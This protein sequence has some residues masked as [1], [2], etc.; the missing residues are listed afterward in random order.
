MSKDNWLDSVN[1]DLEDGLGDGLDDFEFGND[2][3]FNDSF[4][5]T[6]TLLDELENIDHQEKNGSR[7]NSNGLAD[8]S[9]SVGNVESVDEEETEEDYIKR[10]KKGII[11][12]IIVS[13]LLLILIFLIPNIYSGVKAGLEANNDGTVVEEDIN[14]NSVEQ[15]KNKDT[16]G[17]K[18]EP[19]NEPEN[20]IG[21]I[22]NDNGGW[23]EI[24]FTEVEFSDNIEGAFTVTD[25]KYFTKVNKQSGEKQVKALVT[26]AISGL[27]GTYE[28]ELPYTRASLL[29]TGSV[30]K[31]TYKKASLNN[32]S[33]VSDIRY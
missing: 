31:V 5:D 30:F 15:E 12:L 1:S 6:N 26:G 20:N 21:I 17:K 18:D 29:E 9:G 13:V 33:I 27:T 24:S 14:K 25:I 19:V 8:F 23:V 2:N 28:L 22:K 3:L 11:L 4:S 7:K 16:T 32:D 10:S